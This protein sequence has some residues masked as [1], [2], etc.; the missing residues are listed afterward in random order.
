MDEVVNLVR[1]CRSARMR[2]PLLL[3]SHPPN[4][5]AN[6]ALATKK[7]ASQKKWAFE[8]GAGSVRWSNKPSQNANKPLAVVANL[9]SR[10][11]IPITIATV[12][13]AGTKIR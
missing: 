4:V 7:N 10:L 3:A 6:P 2:R 13:V 8:L 1:A 9:V 12:K 11:N 5:A